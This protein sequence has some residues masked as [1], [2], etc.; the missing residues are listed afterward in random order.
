M[1]KKGNNYDSPLIGL[2][3]NKKNDPISVTWCFDSIDEEFTITATTAAWIKLKEKCSGSFGL[4]NT[5]LLQRF[6]SIYSNGMV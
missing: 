3:R 6:R 1:I 5:R 4:C 2:R